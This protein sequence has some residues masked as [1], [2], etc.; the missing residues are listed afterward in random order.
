MLK[1]AHY[2]VQVA[3]IPHSALLAKHSLQMDFYS[4]LTTQIFHV[5]CF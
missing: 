1:N 3:K 5:L 4:F 2:I